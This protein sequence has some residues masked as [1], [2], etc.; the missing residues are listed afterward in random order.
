VTTPGPDHGQLPLEDRSKP[1]RAGR[2]GPPATTA[3]A[4]TPPSPRGRWSRRAP[5]N[6]ERPASAYN[7][8]LDLLA[9]RD[10]SRAEL[11]SRL[12][13]KGFLPE[14]IEP[15]LQ[16]LEQAGLLN[17]ESFASAFASGRAA[18]GI[19]SSVIRRDLVA[20]G[21][22]PDLAARAAA[23]ASPADAEADRCHELAA[24]WL[25]RRPGLQRPAAARRLASYLAR[26]GYPAGIVASVVMSLTDELP[27][28]ADDGLAADGDFAADDGP[29]GP[30]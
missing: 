15:A 22:D 25:S 9:Y 29:A 2:S 19:A 5:A 14:A 10:H 3:P 12:T 28:A 27:T 16:R 6:P 18:R 17:E 4:S 1:Q 7:A 8:A 30:V 23:E 20:R 21:I 11:A 13:R 24:A 26:R